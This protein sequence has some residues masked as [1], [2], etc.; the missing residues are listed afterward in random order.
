M[1]PKKYSNTNI[2][3]VAAMG[4][5]LLVF[6][7][8]VA[9][10]SGSHAP[11]S[12]AAPPIVRLES[13]TSAQQ[14][15]TSLSCQDYDTLFGTNYNQLLYMSYVTLSQMT[16]RVPGQNQSFLNFQ[17]NAAANQAY[18]LYTSTMNSKNCTPS[19]SAPTA[20]SPAA[21]PAGVTDPSTLVGGSTIPTGCAYPVALQYMAS[22]Y[23]QYI[24]NMQNEQTTLTNFVDNLQPPPTSIGQRLQ[25]G[26]I[27]VQAQ[28]YTNAKNLTQLFTTDVGNVGC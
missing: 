1:S 15:S 4:V 21:P 27:S 9:V 8:V 12:S 23:Q 28:F 17:Y 24:V 10:V 3:F 5:F 13:Q 20:L 7:A 26:S 22:Y 11:T 16:N 19:I 14:I 18:G 2:L 6:S 25:S